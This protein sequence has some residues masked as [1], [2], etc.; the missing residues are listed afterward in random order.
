MCRERTVV[1]RPVVV[2][3]EVVVHARPREALELLHLPRLPECVGE[4]V[5]QVENGVIRARA[6]D[7][8]APYESVGCGVQL[9]IRAGRALAARRCVFR[10]LRIREFMKALHEVA[11]AM[12]GFGGVR[13]LVVARLLERRQKVCCVPRVGEDAAEGALQVCLTEVG[14]LERPERERAVGDDVVL[15]AAGAPDAGV[16]GPEGRG[17]RLDLEAIDHVVPVRDAHRR[18]ARDLL[19]RLLEQD[20]LLAVPRE[21]RGSLLVAVA[22]VHVRLLAVLGPRARRAVR[23]AVVEDQAVVRPRGHLLRLVQLERVDGVREG[24]ALG[25]AHRRPVPA[26]DVRAGGH[27]TH[28]ADGDEEAHHLRGAGDCLRHCTAS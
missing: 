19:Q 9:H 7:H 1:D 12:L 17:R 23:L 21:E 14:V 8:R 10:V 22:V 26:H 20:E 15:G 4:R 25:L 16:R 6:V 28:G 24:G 18:V 13:R 27:C 2:R 11:E 3:L 5:K